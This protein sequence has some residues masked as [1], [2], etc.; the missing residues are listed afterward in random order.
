[1]PQTEILTYPLT[2]EM[3]DSVDVLV[4]A[5]GEMIPGLVTFGIQAHPVSLMPVVLFLVPDEGLPLNM[6]KG[7]AAPME[8]TTDGI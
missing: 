3:I 8:I 1:M 2:F 4:G 5:D 7:Y 6:W